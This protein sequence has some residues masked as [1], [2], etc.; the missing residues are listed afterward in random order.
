M[1]N[2]FGRR[3]IKERDD[4]TP[5]RLFFVFTV[6]ELDTYLPKPYLCASRPTSECDGEVQDLVFVRAAASG[7]HLC[8]DDH[9]IDLICI[10]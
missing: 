3:E 6:T 5:S 4:K 9:S 7:Y 8:V 1:G 10:Q 2:G